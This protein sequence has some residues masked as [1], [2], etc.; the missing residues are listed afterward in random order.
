MTMTYSRVPVYSLKLIKERGLRYPL[1]KLDSPNNATSALR[2][3]L[4]DKDCEHLAVL[5][6]DG[7]NNFLGLTTVAIGGIS[8]L[9]AGVRDVFKAAI[10]G[11]ASAII[12]GHNHPSGDPSP[13][14]E[15][16]LF[17]RKVQE[18]SEVLGIPLLDHIIISSGMNLDNFSFLVNGLLN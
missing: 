5:M 2:A 13:S 3:Y 17:T 14:S 9:K 15:D 6:V 18:G 4:Q 7:H 8:G 16:I 11:R 12:L 10:A 1:S